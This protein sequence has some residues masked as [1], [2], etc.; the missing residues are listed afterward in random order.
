VLPVLM[1]VGLVIFFFSIVCTILFFDSPESSDF[2]DFGHSALSLYTLLTTVN[3][4]DV[5][6]PMY[7][8]NYG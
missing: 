1:L 2:R 3:F 8:D 6:M 4:P 7:A 5:M